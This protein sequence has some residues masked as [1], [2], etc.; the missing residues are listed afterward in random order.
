MWPQALLLAFFLVIFTLAFV[1]NVQGPH[2]NLAAVIPFVLLFLL[3]ASSGLTIPSHAAKSKFG[4][5][6]WLGEAT[7]FT[8]DPEGIRVASASLSS[9]IRWSV[10][11]EVCET[12]SLFLLL[13][14]EGSPIIIPKRF[15]ASRAE[16]P[17]WKEL[18]QTQIKCRRIALRGIAARWC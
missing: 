12:G 1:G 15:F 18:V 3:W 8:F 4:G 7:T 10:I 11:R 13:S 6:K 9:E 17:V 5:Q 2:G 14:G 16:M